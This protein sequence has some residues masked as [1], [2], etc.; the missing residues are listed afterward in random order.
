MRISKSKALELIKNNGSKMFT[1]TFVKKN[2]ETRT[3]NGM[4]KTKIN[5]ELGYLKVFENKTKE[6]RNVNLQTL[7]SMSLGGKKYLIT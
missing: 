2:G 6:F 1:S 7:E 4:I 5:S 3:V